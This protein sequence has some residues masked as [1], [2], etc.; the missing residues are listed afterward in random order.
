MTYAKRMVS[1][2]GVDGPAL[3]V[4]I[5][6]AVVSSR[7]WWRRSLQSVVSWRVGIQWYSTAFG[8]PVTFYALAIALDLL[9]GGEPLDLHKLSPA[10]IGFIIFLQHIGTNVWVE[11]GWRGYAL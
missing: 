2:L 11:I 4:F 6:H 8:L 10:F 5:V 9:L 1:F 3:A 7:G